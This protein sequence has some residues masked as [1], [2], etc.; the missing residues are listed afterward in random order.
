MKRWGSHLVL[1]LLVVILAVAAA[2]SIWIVP[3]P[4]AV[5]LAAQ[6]EP[7]F[8]DA[9]EP[10]PPGWKGPVF[11]LRQDYP[12][13]APPSEVL[14]WDTIDPKN[15]PVAYAR[16]VLKYVYE[17]N[18]DVDWQVEQN[19]VRNWYHAPWMHSGDTGREFV[20]GL[21]RERT[22]QPKELAPTQTS[23]FQNWAVSV[24][25]APGGFV[26]GQV[27]K[28]HKSPNPKAAVFPGG[29]VSA[30]L[31][32]SEAN[33]SEVPYLK[34]SVE[35]DANVNQPMTSTTR[36][37][38]KM[39][40]LQ[41]DVAVR[42]PRVDSTTGWVFGTFVYDGNSP[43]TTPWDRMVPV[44]VM[45]GNDPAVP[46]SS[47][48]KLAETRINPALGVAQHLG[49]GGRLNGPVDNP[50]SSC[51]SCHSVAQYEGAA[52]M[53]PPAAA[54]ESEKMKWFR[55]VKAG[56]P[57]TA[58]EVSLD[59]S[60]QLSAGLQHCLAAKACGIIIVPAPGTSPITAAP[61]PGTKKI[62]PVTRGQ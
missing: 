29:T 60:L 23:R 28:S 44:G 2:S 9:H 1:A 52:D 51:L 62:F 5:A 54:S 40:L 49:F 43:G 13:T 20:R 61:T 8:P 26:F 58:G 11:K 41:I 12:A 46:P 21:T 16:A 55:N 24:Y 18:I 59:Y 34:G 6:L 39:R 42:D 32:F 7:P 48:G 35:W 38:S 14:P 15:D 4:T 47:K 17:G 50:R 22:T 37:V 53:M 27:W 25:N 57:F 3:S 45:W 31:L 19:K 36:K 30:K 56:Q 10:P 33:E